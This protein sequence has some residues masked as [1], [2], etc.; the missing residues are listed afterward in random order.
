MKNGHVRKIFAKK[1]VI[2][3]AGVFNTPQ[4]LMLSGI[5]HRQPCNN[6]RPRYDIAWLHATNNLFYGFPS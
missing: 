6:Q 4:L 1:E 5:G 2:L 3:S